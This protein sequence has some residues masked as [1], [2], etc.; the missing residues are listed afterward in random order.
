MSTGTIRPSALAL[1][2]LLVALGCGG[3][4]PEVQEP[5]ARPTGPNRDVFA[6]LPEARLEHRLPVV[7]G[8]DEDLPCFKIAGDIAL[9]GADVMTREVIKEQAA[10][11]AKVVRAWLADRLAPSGIS[12]AL[13]DKWSVEVLDPVVLEVP[14]ERVRFSENP[15]CLSKNGWLP[16]GRYLATA[17]LGGRKF[18]LKSSMPL[19]SDVQQSMLEALGMENMVIDSETL[20]V[21]EAA[22]GGDGQPLLDPEGQPLYTSPSGEFIPQSQVPPPEKRMM[23]EWELRSE[24]PLWFA[25]RALP[26]DGW[27]KEG[28]KDKCNVILIPEALNP[29][30]PECPEFRDAAF[31]VSIL[32]GE[33]KPVSITITTGKDEYKGVVLAWGE[34]TKV[35]VNDRIIL[36]LM[37][38]KVEVG[39][40]LLVNSLVL[41][42]R[43]L[44]A[45]GSAPD[46]ESYA[47][48]PEAK[49][50]EEPPAG[51]AGK[52]GKT[53]K[54]DKGKPAE[55]E[56]IEKPA[57]AKKGK[58]SDSS[59]LDDYLKN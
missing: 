6:P 7:V 2:S 22:R 53:G 48:A 42:P 51:K 55:P 54:G 43:P 59:A 17:L 4:Q 41:D 25:Y 20:F 44:A 13:I 58:T 37:A 39:V 12:P 33:D 40:E 16:E 28:D 21:Y 31:T 27:R 49:R 29:Q 56:K 14:R 50:P 3:K 26:A 9:D 8:A 35:Q 1:A 23:T 45:E 10:A 32:E 30:A 19:G 52:A 11:V 46:D 5:V 57:P 38:K 18:A 36:W 34:G 15:S 47:A 24:S